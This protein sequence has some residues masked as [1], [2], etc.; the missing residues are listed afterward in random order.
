MASPMA[1]RVATKFLA[2]WFVV[3]IALPFTAPCSTFDL[4]DGL[5]GHTQAGVTAVTP[6]PVLVAPIGTDDVLVS[7]ERSH[8]KQSRLC[9][10]TTASCN[11]AASVPLLSLPFDSTPSI[12]LPVHSSPLQAILRL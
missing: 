9:A 11:Q 1:G 5:S 10:L 7:V 4:I 12:V 3:L 2:V 8:L 6:P